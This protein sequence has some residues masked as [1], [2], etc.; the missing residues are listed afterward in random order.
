MADAPFQRARFDADL[1]FK[2]LKDPDFRA[3]LL[4]KPTEVYGEE[5]R[6]VLPEKEIPDGVEIKI[7]E[8]A[9]DVFHVVLPCVPA[10]MELSDEALH[11]VA[12]HEQTHR[13]PCWGL[14]DPPA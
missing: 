14:G 6:R 3:R 8:E 13:H 11:R 4:A 2:A 1:V 7:A 12:R 9:E 5:L 10:G